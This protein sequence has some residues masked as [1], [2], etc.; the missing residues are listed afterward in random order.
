MIRKLVLV[1]MSC[2]LFACDLVKEADAINENLDAKTIWIFAQINVPQKDNKVEDYYYYARVSE[3]LFQRIKDNEIEKGYIFLED[4]KY[5]GDNDLIYDYADNEDV[6]SMLFRIEDIRRIR[7]IKTE[8]KAGMG[9]EQFD[10]L[11]DTPLPTEPLPKTVEMK[12]EISLPVAEL[13]PAV[14]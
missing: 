14:E 8:P 3:S 2:T 11:K 6:G 5:W 12:K 13:L 1:L 10:D 4:I 9:S 7:L